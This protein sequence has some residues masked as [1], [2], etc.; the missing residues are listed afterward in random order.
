M[1]RPEF[2]AWVEQ[3]YTALQ[4]VAHKLVGPNLADDAVQS[5]LTS[6]LVNATYEKMDASQNLL[7]F[8][9][10]PVRRAAWNTRR[11]ESRKDDMVG[12]LAYLT[13]LPNREDT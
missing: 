6:V 7:A 11:G 1:T 3:H 9:G 2:D 4:R 5:A 8:L 13:A 12:E 10:L